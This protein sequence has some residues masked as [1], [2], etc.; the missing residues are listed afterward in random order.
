MDF[1]YYKYLRFINKQPKVTYQD[2]VDR[3]K[4][5]KLD[6]RNILITLARNEY[7]THIGDTYYISTFK[8]K[9]F[10]KSLLAEWLF[11]NLLAIIDLII[12]IFGLVIAF[13][14]LFKE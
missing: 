12:A 14:A 4:L 9:H 6:S 3:Y 5:D 13:V 11:K 10:I 1:S 8:G 7:L 2:L